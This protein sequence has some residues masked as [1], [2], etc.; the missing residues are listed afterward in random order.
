MKPLTEITAQV[1]KLTPDELE[2]LKLLR[3]EIENLEKSKEITETN[4]Q[5]ILNINSEMRS[6][7]ELFFWRLISGLKQHHMMS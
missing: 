7:T 6:F 1:G 5:I 3:R 2:R 4:L